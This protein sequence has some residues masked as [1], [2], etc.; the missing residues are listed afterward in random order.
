MY[1]YHWYSAEHEEVG[2]GESDVY[3]ETDQDFDEEENEVL[4]DVD[5]GQGNEDVVLLEQVS[6]DAIL[7]TE[8]DSSMY[9]FH[10]NLDI[11]ALDSY[12]HITCTQFHHQFS[13]FHKFT[14]IQ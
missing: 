1:E 12:D 4:R 13:F 14:Y 9:G 7:E 6:T 5:D 8:F 3:E 11:I 10:L 2:E